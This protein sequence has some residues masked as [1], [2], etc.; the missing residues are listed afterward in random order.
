MPVNTY[1]GRCYMPQEMKDWLAKT[2]F[3][4]VKTKNLGDTVM[5]TGKKV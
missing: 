3:K 1:A 2:G 5:I 4:N